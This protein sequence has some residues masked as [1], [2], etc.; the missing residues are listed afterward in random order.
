MI[1]PTKY[2]LSTD[3]MTVKFRNSDVLTIKEF[4]NYPLLD[5]R[6]IQALSSIWTMVALLLML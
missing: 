2:P 1:Y 3:G 4:S 5:L 6:L